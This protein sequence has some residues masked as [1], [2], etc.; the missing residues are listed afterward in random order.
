M[1]RKTMPLMVR[2]GD[3]VDMYG[4]PVM[5]TANHGGNVFTKKGEQEIKIAG[6]DEQLWVIPCR[7]GG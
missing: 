4:Q 5:V 2:P 3:C 7:E 6:P 1:R